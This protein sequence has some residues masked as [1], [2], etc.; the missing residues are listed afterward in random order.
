MGSGRGPAAVVREGL[1]TSRTKHQR[2]ATMVLPLN[3]VACTC[4]R[5]ISLPCQAAYPRKA[6]PESLPGRTTGCTEARAATRRCC[7]VRQRGIASS[8]LARPTCSPSGAHAGGCRSVTRAVICPGDG[9]ALEKYELQQRS[10]AIRWLPLRPRSRACP[11]QR[12]RCSHG[13]ARPSASAPREPPHRSSCEGI[14]PESTRR[15]G[16]RGH[17]GR[18]SPPRPARTL[19]IE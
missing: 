15:P 6:S 3:A 14:R 4:F 12:R 11:R 17:G 5:W 16:K 9:D 10:V 8:S 18:S 19:E 13:A 2:G 1:A 7:L